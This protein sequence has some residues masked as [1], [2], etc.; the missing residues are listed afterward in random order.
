MATRK[1]AADKPKGSARASTPKADAKD[2]RS[3]DSNGDKVGAAPLAKEPIVPG[4]AGRSVPASKAFGESTQEE[5]RR[6][7]IRYPDSFYKKPIPAEEQVLGGP[8]FEEDEAKSSR[9]GREDKSSTKS[10]ENKS[11]T[12]TDDEK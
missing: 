11:S 9:K 6:S 2:T 7:G 10:E 12:K 1:N 8:R 3:T 4:H 5:H